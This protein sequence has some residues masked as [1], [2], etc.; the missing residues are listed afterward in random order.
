MVAQSTLQAPSRG[1]FEP[2]LRGYCSDRTDWRSWNCGPTCAAAVDGFYHDRRLDIDYVRRLAGIGECGPTGA[3]SVQLMLDRLNVPADPHYGTTLSLVKQVVAKRTRPIIVAVRM[4]E[5]PDGYSGDTYDGNHWLEILANTVDANGQTGVTDMD[6][7]APSATGGFHFIPDWALARS[8]MGDAVIP[9]YAKQ[10]DKQIGYRAL[11]GPGTVT[12]WRV[13][14]YTYRLSD[15]QDGVWPSQSWC[16]VDPGVRGFWLALNGW[17]K[18]RYFVDSH[19]GGPVQ[20]QRIYQ[21]PDGSKYYK[22]IA[23]NAY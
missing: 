21:R 11:V 13:E 16:L 17:Y 2:P 15:R 5:I 4:G 7:N 20:I 6:S 10:L 14:R 19:T 12:A 22:N 18:G 23:I 8:L 1:Q 3:A 9:R